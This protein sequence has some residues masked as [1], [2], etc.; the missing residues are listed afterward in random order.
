MAP[1]TQPGVPHP[2]QSPG[3]GYRPW[4]W[5]LG[6]IL[7]LVLLGLV[8]PR[9]LAWAARQLAARE[10]RRGAVSSAQQ[11]LAKARALAP[12]D[13][14]VLV[15]EAAC[16]R[17]LRQ[18][19]PF[20]RALETAE[21]Q[22]GPAAMI[23]QERTLGLI[24]AGRFDKAG[25]R[26]PAE[27]IAA[28]FSPH[29][30]AGAFVCGL[31]VR[32]Q[33]EEA[34]KA[35]DAWGGDF[36]H[37]PQVAYMEGIYWQW[38]GDMAKA[39]AS[40]RQALAQEPR[41]ELARMALA[42]LLEQDDRFA[43]ALEQYARWADD[44][45]SSALARAGLARC[46]RSMGRWDEAR[47]VLG[48]EAAG[49]LP[50]ALALEM[51]HVELESGD[52]SA[53]RQWLEH[54]DCSEIED[55]QTLRALGTA[56]ALTDQAEKA[57]AVFA[58]ADTA[59]GRARRIEDL[60]ARLA[61]DPSDP[62]R[63]GELAGLVGQAQA[64]VAAADAGTPPP[65]RPPLADAATQPGPATS[66]SDL[67]VRW[68]AAC[69][70]T[71]GR[72]DGPAARHLYPP[73]RDFHSESFRL[74]STANAVPTR[75][76]VVAAIARGMPGTA[77]RAFDN[78]SNAEV[79]QLADEV[80]AWYRQGIREQ[81]RAAMAAQHEELEP[82]D[83][84]EA[85]R[86]RDTPGPAIEVPPLGPFEAERAAQGKKT[87]M[88]LGC[89]KCHGEDGRGIGDL[90]LA[91][92]KGNPCVPRDL[93][94][95][96]FKGGHEP[97]ALFLRI[98]GGLPGTPHPA[99]YQVAPQQIVEVVHYCQAIAQEPKRTLTNHQRMTEAA[100]WRRLESMGSPVPS[101]AAARS[102][103]SQGKASPSKPPQ[104]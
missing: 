82:E 98:R 94:L 54:V 89:A 101:P 35:L 34:R 27:L 81:L 90:P 30:V 4:L 66:A 72:G 97:A 88:A 78:L 84:E 70:G 65:R 104:L 86:L 17:Q 32:G 21:K 68:C 56:L 77:M 51:A 59:S 64:E 1:R 48:S 60:R 87:Y 58:R 5:A 46:L 52:P 92:E 75:E 2:R 93:A 29:E 13:T 42:E 16:F 43:E 53:A 74:V 12:A 25:G 45:P 69:H 83:L 99:C 33:A 79:Q 71:E 62:A 6:G 23:A 76:D 31:L 7:V 102:S 8:V 14:R 3:R 10:L 36:P 61:I 37:H 80:L 50:A 57:A 95:D 49:Q 9:M 28:G 103:P 67:Y 47:L 39:E 44:F 96:P 24:Q 73:P 41:H 40:F 22:G 85:V 18:V 11:W 38:L 91:D 26:Q 20:V 100:A 63:R 15:L 19:R 55:R